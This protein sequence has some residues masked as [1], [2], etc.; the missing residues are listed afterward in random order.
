MSSV[1]SDADRV[2]V[3]TGMMGLLDEQADILA[4]W[5]AVAP[6][7][8]ELA[9]LADGFH[10]L[11]RGLMAM[12]DIADERRALAAYKLNSYAA[13]KAED[14]EIDRWQS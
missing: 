13:D 12:A 4:D 2:E 5:G 14:A 1:P 7:L 10:H 11:I 9:V 8:P 6:E 3:L